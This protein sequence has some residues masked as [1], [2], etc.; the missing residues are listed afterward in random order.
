M[1]FVLLVGMVLVWAV[2]SY[3]ALGFYRLACAVLAEV[4]YRSLVS[5]VEIAIANFHGGRS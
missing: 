2:A 1:G 3:T 4:R 5:K